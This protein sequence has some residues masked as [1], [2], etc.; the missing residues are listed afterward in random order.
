MKAYRCK[1]SVK[2]SKP[3][4]WVRCWIPGG[5]SFSALSLLLDEITGERHGDDFHFEIFRQA[6]VWEPSK[7]APLRGD[8]YH[9]AYSAAHTSVDE[10]FK[11]GLALTYTGSEHTFRIQVEEWTEGYS[12]QYPKLVKSIS[13]SDA[14]K[15]F[16]RLASGVSVQETPCEPLSRRELQMSA[17]D[18]VLRLG[19]VT[20][21][22]RLDETY[23][24]S[25]NSFLKAMGEMLKKQS[26]DQKT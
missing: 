13:V 5:I 2:D 8:T 15:R 22:V 3:P 16:D 24:P 1:V 26:K 14:Q 23:M 18:G 21:G 20:G 9:D 12:F 19:P 17:S 10:L 7:D 25:T 6:R 4:V 11:V